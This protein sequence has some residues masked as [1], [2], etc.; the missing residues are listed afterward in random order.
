[1]T[2]GG[3]P[4]HV[5][6]VLLGRTRTRLADGWNA[7]ARRGRTSTGRLTV[8]VS[9]W[10]AS[11]PDDAARDEGPPARRVL[12]LPASA[13]LTRAVTGARRP[14]LDAWNPLGPRTPPRWPRPV[15]QH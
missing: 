12:P 6:G 8:P 15:P 3:R 9:A 5:A 14:S 2:G 11:S 7:A 1:M 10:A 13:R 4:L